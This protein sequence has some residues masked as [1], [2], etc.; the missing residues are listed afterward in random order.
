MRLP[1]PKKL[2]KV[3]RKAFVYYWLPVI[4]WLGVIAA[5]S[6]S[7][8]AASENTSRIVIPVLHWL[9]P[10]LSLAE[11]AEIHHVLRKIGHFGGYGLLS[12]FFFRALCGTHH[13]YAGTQN[14]LSRAY[15]RSGASVRFTDYWR[16]GWA[17]WAL[18]GT[19]MVA[20]L[21]ELHQMTLANRTGS[22]K[23]VL[24][25]S[26]GAL[27]FQIVIL[28]FVWMTTRARRRAPERVKA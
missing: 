14:L 12:F 28:G 9:M 7:V 24:L 10:R 6:I 16:A 4:V 27:I 3:T 18:I 15:R 13:I 5:E 20:S 26:I 11:L 2:P 22:W 23:D 17:I 21:D 8:F 19:A 1:G 25:D